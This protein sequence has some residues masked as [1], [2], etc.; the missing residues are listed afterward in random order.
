MKA[1]VQRVKEA[2]VKVNDKVIGEI[3]S[4]LLVLIGF[5]HSDSTSDIEKI[6]KKVVSC[7]IFNDELGKMNLSLKEIEGELLLISQFTLYA[8]TKK[9]NRPS[10]IE[11]AKPEYAEE[12][13]N[14]AIQDFK[15]E[16]GMNIATGEFGADMKVSLLNDGPVTLEIEI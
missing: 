3:G 11:A 14:K 1:L 8:N 7:R 12:L 2:N 6:C 9:G 15:K 4:G 13:Y 16:L 5:T 10:F